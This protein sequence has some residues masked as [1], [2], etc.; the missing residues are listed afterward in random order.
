M[1]IAGITRCRLYCQ[2]HLG[3]DTGLGLDHQAVTILTHSWYLPRKR[4][5]HLTIGWNDHPTSKHC[6]SWFV[7]ALVSWCINLVK[8][9]T[10]VTV[11]HIQV[12]VHCRTN[13]NG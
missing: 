6:T 4:H 12:A 1:R 9:E 3:I 5:R 7:A 2:V 13:S 11:T 8:L 10:W